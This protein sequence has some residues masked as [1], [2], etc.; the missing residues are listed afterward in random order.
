[1]LAPPP[2]RHSMEISGPVLISSSNPTA[3]ARIGEISGGL[4]CSAPSQVRY[5]PG[6]EVMEGEFLLHWRSPLDML[7]KIRK[8]IYKSMAN[9]LHLVNSLSVLNKK[10]WVEV[11]QQ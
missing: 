9:T 2:Q 1:M 10:Y 4:S 6:R 11:L 8:F 7:T 3:A 5:S